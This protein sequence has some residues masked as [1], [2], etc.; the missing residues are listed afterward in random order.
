ADRHDDIAQ[1][2]IQSITTD[3]VNECAKTGKITESSW[4]TFQSKLNSQ[5]NATYDID[6][7]V[8]IMNPTGSKKSEQLQQGAIGTNDYYSEY[9]TSIVDQLKRNGKYDLKSGD[10]ITVKVQNSSAT[11]GDTMTSGFLKTTNGD[12]VKIKADATATVVTNGSNT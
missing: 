10:M 7:E 6:I 11:S 4:D 1:T 9:T 3:F 8:A 5:G 12:S 2:E